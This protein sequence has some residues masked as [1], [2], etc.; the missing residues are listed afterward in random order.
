M[1]IN[2]TMSLWDMLH[3][4][5]LVDVDHPDWVTDKKSF[6]QLAEWGNQVVRLNNVELEIIWTDEHPHIYF[7]AER[8]S[9]SNRFYR[10]WLVARNNKLDLD[11]LAKK[12]NECVKFLGD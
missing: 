8:N 4:A 11:N 7:R 5:G 10:R 2:N 12:Y 9:Q 3:A 1:I 6:T